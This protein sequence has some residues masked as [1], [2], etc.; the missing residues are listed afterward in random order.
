MRAYE[1]YMHYRDHFPVNVGKA[2]IG[3]LLTNLIG[4]ATYEI[5]DVRL[6]LS[7]FWMLGEKLI[8]GEAHDQI[9]VDEMARAFASG[10]GSFVDIGANIGYFTLLAA[11]RYGAT[12]FA[13]EPSPRELRALHDNLLLNGVNQAV[14]FPFALSDRDGVVTLNICG[15]H[16]AG[17]NS[18]VDLRELNVYTSTVEVQTRRFDALMTPEMLRDVRLIK[19]DVEGYEAA[20]IQG[21]E[22]AMPA[23]ANC[24]FVVE[25]SKDYLSRSRAAA[26]DVYAF[27]ANFGYT[28]R[29][30]L[31]TAQ[32]QYD[33][34]FAKEPEARATPV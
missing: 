10:R 23:L 27:F 5:G 33:E 20:V 22:K 13:F 32:S 1:L 21:M 26:A 6:R 4:P 2:R 11:K 25:I 18:V 7:P 17:M 12:V 29:F 30:G 14:V 19:I 28:P 16:N 24:R 9:V 15:E 8:K 3:R 34:V 31:Q